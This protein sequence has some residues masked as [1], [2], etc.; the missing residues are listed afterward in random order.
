MI[1][2]TAIKLSSDGLKNIVPAAC[3]AN[4]DFLF[5]FGEKEIKMN[6]IFAEFISPTV[7][8]LHRTDPTI[9]SICFDE[10]IIS[11]RS[12][13]VNT[14]QILTEDIISL[15]LQVATGHSIELNEEQGYKMRIISIL[16]DNQELF[17]KI[18]EIYPNESNIDFCIQD[19][20]FYQQQSQSQSLSNFDYSNIINTIASQFYSINENKLLQL[21]KSILY[22]II[23]ND[24]LKLK[25]EDSLFSFIQKIFLKYSEEEEE[26]YDDSEEKISMVSFYEAVEF[27]ELSESKFE[28]FVRNFDSNEMSKKLWHKLFPCFYINFNK[29]EKKKMV[30]NQ[31]RYLAESRHFDYDGN[32]DHSFQ[33]IIHKLTEEAGGNVN[34]KGVVKV[35]SS[36]TNG[37]EVISKHA[38][39]FEDNEH[40]FQSKNEPN[41]WLMYDFQDSKV[42]PTHYSIRT[43]PDGGKGDNHP[44]NWVIEGSNTEDDDDW[45]ILDSRNDITILDD[46]NASHTFEIQTQLESNESFRYLRLRQTGPNTQTG[47]Y[48]FLTLSALEYFGILYNN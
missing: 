6:T 48:Y 4:S 32:T 7:S 28:E 14:D 22:R 38:V 19:L 5:I 35:S 41:S 24:N 34:D 43:R 21:P 42:K 46:S 36:P 45:V 27:L 33:G 16:L 39:D 15:L 11:K 20:L 47:N 26:D 13:K 12:I 31:Q 10:N 9:E 17:L 30:L 3:R 44:K 23:T 8:R 2:E 1:G 37:N 25:N 29:S 18:N 40:Y